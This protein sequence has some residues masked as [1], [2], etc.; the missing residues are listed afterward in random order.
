VGFKSTLHSFK[1]VVLTFISGVKSDIMRRE[2]WRS[3]KK[4]YALVVAITLL[5]VLALVIGVD[6]VPRASSSNPQSLS[7]RLDAA[8]GFTK[9]LFNPLKGLCRETLVKQNETIL[10]SNGS[11]YQ[12]HTNE[13][14]WIASDNYL[15]SLALKNYNTTL[16][17][18]INQTCSKYYNG[19]YPPYQIMQGKPIPTTLHTANTY[20]LENASDHVI[21]LNL[22]NGTPRVND[23][24]FTDYPEYGDTL[25][26][27]AINYYVQGYPLDWCDNLYMHAYHMFDGKGVEDS[28]FYNSSLY[29]NMKLA[30]LIFSAKV[31]NLTQDLTGIE[32]QLWKAQKTSGVEAGGI[33]SCMN[34]SG[35]PV[36]T[37]NGETTALTL[38]AYDDNSIK[39]IQLKRNQTQP[40]DWINVTFPATTFNQTNS[41]TNSLAAIP[42]LGN[43]KVIINNTV[44]WVPFQDNPRVA[45]GFYSSLASPGNLSITLVE[46]NN[47]CLD[48]IAQNGSKLLN[49]TYWSNPLAISLASNTLNVSSPAGTYTIIF[50]SFRLAYITAGSTPL[51]PHTNVLGVCSGGQVGIIVPEFPLNL[52]FFLFIILTSLV[53]GCYRFADG[54]DLHECTVERSKRKQSKS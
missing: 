41:T 17:E 32:Q 13:T 24:T 19:S 30:L 27:E 44:Q 14:Y 35:Y 53:A 43:W 22:Y 54:P 10:A 33:T 42:L 9:E 45:L 12:C 28:A 21:A 16:S 7:T 8:A 4:L 1:Y 2:G 3:M 39:Q 38:L 29:A 25:V 6:V 49:N 34:S 18:L 20:V 37:A 15:E 36:G 46:Y 23:K 50:P 47:T 11:I 52:A 26:Y 48:I 40:K 31:L 5:V 51:I